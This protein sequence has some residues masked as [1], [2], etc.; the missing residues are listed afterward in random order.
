LDCGFS[1][2]EDLSPLKDMPLEGHYC[3]D[4]LLKDLKTLKGLPLARLYCGIPIDDLPP[5]RR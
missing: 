2:V 5:L 4:T 3:H 1:G